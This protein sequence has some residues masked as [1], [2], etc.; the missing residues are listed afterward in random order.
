M[1]T[2]KN[3]SKEREGIINY[4]LQCNN[5][6]SSA[7][8]ENDVKTLGAAKMMIK[9]YIINFWLFASSGA[10]SGGTIA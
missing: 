1:N 5:N 4:K 3:R 6:C 2:Y 9:F 10:K 8:W 7:H